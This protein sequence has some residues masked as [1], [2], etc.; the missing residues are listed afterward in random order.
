VTPSATKTA[1]PS[2]VLDE[3]AP[4][5]S[6]TPAP[7]TGTESPTKSAMSRSAV[8]WS[9]FSGALVSSTMPVVPLNTAPD[10]AP[11]SA[12]PAKKSARFEMPSRT[13]TTSTREACSLAVTSWDTTPEVNTRKSVAPAR[14]KQLF[15]TPAV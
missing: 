14:G 11:I 6:A 7:T 15:R 10:P 8:I 3:L 2:T 9:R 12:P 4:S 1:N 5:L 13:E